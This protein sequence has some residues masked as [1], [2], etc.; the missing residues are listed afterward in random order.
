MSVQFAV[1]SGEQLNKKEVPL[2][3]GEFLPYN[4]RANQSQSWNP[5]SRI[6]IFRGDHGMDMFFRIDNRP[7]FH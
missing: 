5:S 7:L 3:L 6:Q 1:L 4:I 2:E